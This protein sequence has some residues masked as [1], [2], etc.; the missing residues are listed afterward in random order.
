[1]NEQFDPRATPWLIDDAEF[2]EL[3]S[4]EE[5]VRFLLQYAILAPSS[6][7]T[8]PWSFHAAGD[9]I[10]VHADPSRRL[11]VVDPDDRELLL[12][13]GAAIA[14]LRIAAAH[15]GFE[16]TVLYTR[17][18]E[19]PG[20][21]AFIA[22]RETSRPDAD[23]SRLFPAI[24]QRHTN[25]QPFEG[26]PVDPDVLARV[27][28]F[29]EQYP[30]T[31]RLVV[32]HDRHRVT[33]LVM[34]ADERQMNDEAFRNELAN[35]VHGDRH[36]K[37]GIAADGLG[38]SPALSAA[39]DWVLRHVDVGSIEA[40][41]DR[42]LLDSA[43]ALVVVAAEDDRVALVAAGEVMERLL[44]TITREG[45][46]YSFF[47]GPIEIEELRHNMWTLVGS[48]HPPQLL[49]RVGHA[50][51]TPRAMPRRPVSEVMV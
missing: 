32:P 37:D 44:L 6:H 18:A 36:H 50:R 19:I 20:L 17:N 3:E 29:V 10:E 25:R 13:V 22:L 34:L 30:D 21:V 38:F 42:S 48:D 2:Y 7:N 43:A 39:A 46:H 11:A 47:N 40:K 26:E 9:G 33:D 24:K 31:L 28:D 12:S 45:L 27:C 35:W 4:F 16:S 5:Q 1:M 23:L 14:N 51:G 15:F 8:Q 49:L 41:R